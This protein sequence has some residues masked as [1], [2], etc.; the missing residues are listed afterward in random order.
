M[1]IGKRDQLEAAYRDIA[2][3]AALM[4]QAYK[5]A[6]FTLEQ[7]LWLVGVWQQAMVQ[8]WTS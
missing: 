4:F 5:D 3:G 8:Q 7:A 2:E 1:N 6:G